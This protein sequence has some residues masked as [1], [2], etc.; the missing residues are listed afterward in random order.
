MSKQRLKLS[1]WKRKLSGRGY[2]CSDIE[3]STGLEAYSFTVSKGKNHLTLFFD[4]DNNEKLSFCADNG[5]VATIETFDKFIECV[6]YQ[7]T[8]H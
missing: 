1:F 6:N 8:A 3:W 5:F 7:P 4:S 2:D